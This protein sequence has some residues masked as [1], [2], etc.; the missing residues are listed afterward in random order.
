MNELPT[1]SAAQ[2]ERF[3]AIALANLVREYPNKQD[4]VLGGDADLL[5]SRALHPAFCTS[6]DWHSCVHMHWLIVHVRRRFPALERRAAID[7]LLERHLVPAKIMAECAY[8]ARP[9][10]ES[11]ERTYGWAWL[12]KLA[13]E[14]S[15]SGDDDARRWTAGAARP[16]IRRAI[17]RVPATAGLPDPPRHPPEQRVRARV[18]ARLRALRGRTRAR[19][20]LCGQGTRMV[21]RRS[22]CACCV[23]TLRD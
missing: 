17:S 23:G 9:G 14:L 18:R 1:L 19:S 15:T 8:L 11:F 6:F 4:H 5:P 12:L 2:A 7:A 10:T 22:R 21:W 13:G 20:A 16:H 3:A